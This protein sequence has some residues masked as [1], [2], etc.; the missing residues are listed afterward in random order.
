MAWKIP[1]KLECWKLPARHVNVP[2]SL[3]GLFT[4]SK[5]FMKDLRASEY[6]LHKFQEKW[7]LNGECLL[8]AQF[9]PPSKKNCRL[10]RNQPLKQT[11]TW[12]II[13][14]NE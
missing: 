10:Q 14:G 5:I 1:N 4:P 6:F 13:Q 9:V 2:K 12:R 3:V 8:Y 11:H 7:A